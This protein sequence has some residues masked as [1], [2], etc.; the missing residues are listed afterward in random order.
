MKEAESHS[1]TES[2][3]PW[4]NT[5]LYNLAVILSTPEGRRQFAELESVMQRIQSRKDAEAVP[6]IPLTPNEKKALVFIRS[7]LKEARSPGV[8]KIAQAAGLGSSRSGAH[9]LSSL[10]NKGLVSVVGSPQNSHQ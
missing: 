7:E 9:L 6:D 10:Q 1:P 8:R 3:M 4:M 5:M 2:K